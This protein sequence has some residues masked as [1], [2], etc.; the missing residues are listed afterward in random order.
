MV[1]PDESGDDADQFARREQVFRLVE[2]HQNAGR[3]GEA[4]M[5]IQQ[6][7]KTWPADP[8]AIHYLG[9]IAYQR[10]EIGHAFEHVK[11]SVTLAPT[12]ALYHSNL[13]EMYRLFG[14]PD[15]AVQCGEHA[16]AL[17]PGNAQMLNS[18]GVAYYERGDH[19]K[20]ASSYRQAI[21]LDSRFSKAF[22]NLGNVLK[23][24][25]R[26]GEAAAAYSSF[27]T[28]EPHA[29]AV[30]FSYADAIKF[31][32]DDP[33][34]K[35]MESM[36]GGGLPLSDMDRI[37]LDFA[38]AKA[39]SDL[40]DHGR[41]FRHLL[42]GN[43][44]KRAQIRYDEGAELA[45]IERIAG[46]FTAKLMSE[47][48]GL[49]TA[50]ASPIPVFIVGMPRS[51]STLVE[52]I[53]AS[54]PDVHA[55]GE[56]SALY[57]VASSLGGPGGKVIPYPEF[58]PALDAGALDRIGARYLAI[59]RKL[60]PAA[61]HV[62]DKRLSNY[63]FAGLIHLAL[64]R[65]RIIH[66]VRD[67][68]DTCVSCFSK[69]FA[70]GQNH[71][72]YDL[73]ELGRYYRRYRG[74]MAKWQHV[75]PPARILEV[76]YEDVVADLEGQARRIVAYCGLGWDTRCLSFQTTVRPVRTASAAQVRQPIYRSAVGRSQVYE[77]FLGPL[78]NALA[79]A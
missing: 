74:L 34:L 60:A 40:K 48:H 59:L 23:D 9:L 22:N 31:T 64:P 28:L 71:Y 77:E 73:A 30:H 43:A 27:L 7:L 29:A 16:T 17:Q 6:L 35:T 13:G 56:R 21:A 54:H 75:L 11:R 51:G 32:A 18:L 33:H 45:L 53:L 52:Q 4:S 42:D 62:T 49:A 65:A 24:L 79:G 61:S 72:T 76:R 38:L 12:I 57:E 8:Q 15:L 5:L 46:T 19:E 44:R 26:P 39:Y 37:H 67:P 41:S 10:G 2:Q 63:Y 25:G 66:T 58:A 14:Q 68:V 47:K 36:S 1:Q 20:A 3:L 70:A 69:L 55:G 50:A 78:R